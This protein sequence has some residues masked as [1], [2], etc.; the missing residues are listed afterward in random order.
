[1]SAQPKFV[2][3]LK[4]RYL[5]TNFIKIK[6]GIDAPLTCQLRLVYNENVGAA[7]CVRKRGE[8]WLIHS[9]PFPGLLPK[10]EVDKLFETFKNSALKC[11]KRAKFT[12]HKGIPTDV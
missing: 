7:I 4:P 8:S 2:P 1:M 12:L 10:V 6:V 9:H 11:D 3:D 5:M